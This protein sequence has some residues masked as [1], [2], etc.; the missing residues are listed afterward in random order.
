MPPRNT[1]KKPREVKFKVQNSLKL[2]PNK[3]VDVLSSGS[4]F[5]TVSGKKYIP[6]LGGKDN[7]PNLLIEARLNSP[8]Q[9]ACISSIAQ[10]V[11]GKGIAVKDV[12]TPNKD[13]FQWFKS[14]NNCGHSINDIARNG[15]DGER[16]HGNQFIEIVRGQIAGKKFM[17]VY[18]HSMLFTRLNE[19][20]DYGD[21]TSVVIS[22]QIAKSGYAILNDD[23]LKIPLWNANPL[24]QN[25]VWLE[26]KG[27]QRTMLHFKNEVSGIEHYGL[28]ASIA[29]LRYQILE[30]KSA[31]YNIDN[32]ENNMILGGM[33]V[34]KASMTQE[35][36]QAQANEILM[37]HVG[38]GKTGRIAVISSESGI[39][40]VDFKPFT[41]KNDGSFLELDQNLKENIIA[42]NNYSGLLIGIEHKGSLG[43]GSGYI[44][45]VYDTVDATLLNPLE[46]RFMEKVMTP[47][48]QIYADWF[49]VS[50][51]LNYNFHFE[52][53][54][55]YSF[56]GDLN[57]ATFTKVNEARV[58]AGMQPD[59]KNGDKY[60]SEMGGSKSNNN[61]QDNQPSA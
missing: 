35:E 36:A 55:P 29:G 41:T 19:P 2:D 6:F 46:R 57:P 28:P 37:T 34:F 33:L 21:P 49:G 3:P 23:V 43:R 5:R 30:A 8:T 1:E 45:S 56:M 7:L 25:D 10:S 53:A 15:I 58:L 50:E 12:Q 13:L 42:A 18:N 38:D 26:D 59:E 44:R 52:T 11:V 9:N 20:D 51:V 22:K 47:I 31:Q 40:D 61:V 27:V 24:N 54:M 4:L 32:F 14:V 39:Q 60:L 16:T 17:K 48:M